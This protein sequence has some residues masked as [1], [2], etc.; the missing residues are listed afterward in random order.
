VLT[1]GRESLDCCG[2]LAIRIRE[3]GRLRVANS[4]ITHARH[5]AAT[6]QLVATVKS[7]ATDDCGS[8][9]SE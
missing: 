2:R 1:D 5:R 9:V 7:I 3:F 8:L 6:M 4:V